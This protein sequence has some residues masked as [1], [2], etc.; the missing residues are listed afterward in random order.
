MTAK[1]YLYIG[2]MVV[3]LSSI[4][5]FI[6]V[7]VSFDR[8]L[9]A[10]DLGD[11]QVVYE[12]RTPTERDPSITRSEMNI[13]EDEIEE[14]LA[15]LPDLEERYQEISER[16]ATL[17]TQIDEANEAGE[18]IPREIGFLQEDLEEELASIILSVTSDVE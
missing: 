14:R 5:T 10:S 17:Q 4:T 16:L 11:R 12:L 15:E 9:E 8:L 2:L 3:V 13:T 18:D 7:S 1:T 6:V